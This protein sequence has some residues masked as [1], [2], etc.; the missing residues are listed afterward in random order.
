MLAGTYL[1][2]YGRY[3]KLTT[4]VRFINDI[5]LSAPSIVIGLFVYEIVVAPMGHFSAIA[6]VVA[7]AHAGR[8]RSS[9]AP[10]RTC[11]CWCRARC[12]KRRRRSACRARYVIRR[13][14]YRAARAGIITGV[15]LAVARIQRRD[16][17]AAVHRAE[18]SVLEHR[19][20]R[21]DGEPAGR[22]LPVRAEP[23]KDWQQLAWTGALLITVAV[24]ALSIAARALGAQRTTK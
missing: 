21:A 20:Q 18:Q 12:A 6:G 22:D 4:V 8:F 9:C 15:L 5:L 19:S 14:A 16:R 2:E 11:C 1:A 7:L 24:L 13:V 23:Y 17:A 3:S 10:P